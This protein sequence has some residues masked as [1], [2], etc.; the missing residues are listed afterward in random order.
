VG[1]GNSNANHVE[2]NPT[3]NI[4]VPVTTSVAQTSS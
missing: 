2:Q 3:F 4:Q 1:H